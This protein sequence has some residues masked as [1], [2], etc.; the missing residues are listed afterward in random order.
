[1]WKVR[2]ALYSNI[3]YPLVMAALENFVYVEYKVQAGGQ[4]FYFLN[5]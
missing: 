2:N 3:L 1:M 4:Y 5:L